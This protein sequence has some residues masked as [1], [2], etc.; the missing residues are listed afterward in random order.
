MTNDRFKQFNRQICLIDADERVAQFVERTLDI[1]LR[2]ISTPLRVDVL[3]VGTISAFIG[4]D[5]GRNY[6][7]LFE[8][9]AL[10]VKDFHHRIR[11]DEIAAGVND[12]DSGPFGL[13][14]WYARRM[15]YKDH[16]EV[17][18]VPWL[19]VWQTMKIDADR[20]DYERRLR[21]VIN[22]KYKV[23]K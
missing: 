10:R 18:R 9:F 2:A 17:L 16:D 11:D 8:K 14:D 13:V 19:R 20:D 5:P 15:G 21:D 7:F 4:E 23:K 12:L 1:V 6:H 22:A 3:R